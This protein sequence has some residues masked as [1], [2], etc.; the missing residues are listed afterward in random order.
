[1]EG[2]EAPSVFWQMLFW[3]RAKSMDFQYRTT[4]SDRHV[5]ETTTMHNDGGT[6]VLTLRGVLFSGPDFDSLAPD[7]FSA[8]TLVGAVDFNRVETYDARQKRKTSAV[9]FIDS[10]ENW[11]I[12]P[13]LW[14]T[15]APGV[16]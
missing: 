8:P 16:S 4:Y 6:L 13:Q 11:D 12:K 10:L 5:V 9:G 15:D 7:S 1:M 2:V 3:V 14:A